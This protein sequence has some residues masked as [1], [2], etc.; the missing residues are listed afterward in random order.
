MLLAISTSCNSQD[1]KEENFKCSIS[2]D[3]VI[4]QNLL[5]LVDA[6]AE[7]NDN[8]NIVRQPITDGTFKQSF[9]YRWE[10]DEATATHLNFS[11]LKIYLYSKVNSS[12]LLDGTKLL[13]DPKAHAN[14]KSNWI[15]THDKAIYTGAFTTGNDSSLKEWNFSFSSETQN[16]SYTVQQQ[17]D[18]LKLLE[19]EPYL[20]YTFDHTGTGL[21]AK[22]VVNTGQKS[23]ESRGNDMTTISMSKSF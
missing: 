16:Y 12:D 22:L 18:Y 17:I 19:T 11:S 5:I 21:N 23:D 10:D 2:Y 13:K 6:Y 20:V 15:Y 7:Y 9:S 8:G 4:P 3:V 14:N 1:E